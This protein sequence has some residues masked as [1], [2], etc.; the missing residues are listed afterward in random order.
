VR[1]LALAGL[2]AALALPVAA[3]ADPRPSPSQSSTCDH[4]A[5]ALHT[6]HRHVNYLH[7]TYTDCTV[8]HHIGQLWLVQDCGTSMCSFRHLD[9]WWSCSG[10]KTSYPGDRD[11]WL[12]T[13]RSNGRIVQ[14]GWV[15]K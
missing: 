12:A 7:Q 8:A 14:I 9:I 1:R 13:C 4:S 3:S 10:K 11:E 5:V 15:R 2:L 6:S